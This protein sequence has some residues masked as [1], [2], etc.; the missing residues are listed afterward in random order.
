MLNISFHD[1]PRTKK[2]VLSLFGK[3]VDQE[4]YIIESSTKQRVLGSDGQEISFDK[5]GVIKNGSEIYAKDDIVSLVGFYEKY[6][7]SQQ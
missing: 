1:N 5:F 7:A 3:E 2:F 6:I 4:S